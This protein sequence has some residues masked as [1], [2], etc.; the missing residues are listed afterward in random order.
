[1]P[2]D[3]LIVTSGNAYDA[4]FKE[5]LPTAAPST[6]ITNIDRI[7]CVIAGPFGSGKSRLLSTARK[8]VL[9]Y[10]LEDRR[11]S[12]AGIPDV[13]VRTLVD[14]DVM[15]PTAWNDLESDIG[16]LEYLKSQGKLEIK[17]IG[18][19][20]LK[21]A[22]A[23]GT[24]EMMN[25][26][27]NNSL[28]REKRI[29]L[30]TYRISQGWDSV[31]YVQRMLDGLFNRLFALDIDIYCTTHIRKQKAA[32]STE[33]NPKFT[34]KWTVDPQQIEFLVSKFNERWMMKDNFKVQVKQDWEYNAITALD[35]DDMMDAN[36]EAMLKMHSS[37][38][39]KR[40]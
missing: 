36:I 22:H 27:G 9:I 5:H 10:D 40:M 1:L 2:D 33:D 19:D 26:Q 32:D 7:K 18:I 12:V 34:G 39:S 6:T 17:S 38:L 28:R 37:R 25:T 16:S 35:I 31:N 4:W 3:K 20:T 21:A 23:I 29:G 8:P 30:K 24:N 13:F 15:Q 11:E 14:R